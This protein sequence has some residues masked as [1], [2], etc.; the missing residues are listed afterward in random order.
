MHAFF[1]ATPAVRRVSS[2][3]ATHPSL[4]ER[5]AALQ[6]YAGGRDVPAAGL[7]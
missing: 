2:F 1:I 3:F 6:I 4:E 7:A 5:I